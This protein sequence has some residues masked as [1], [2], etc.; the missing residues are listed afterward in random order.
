MDEDAVK[1]FSERLCGTVAVSPAAFGS[2]EPYAVCL[3]SR[4]I[5]TPGGR[6]LVLPSKALADAVAAEWRAQSERVNISAMTH[7]RLAVSALDRVAEARG[8]VIDMLLSYAGADLLCYR[9]EAPADLV[10]RQHEH[11]QP[12]LDWAAERWGAHL[13]VTGGIVPVAQPKAAIEALRAPVHALDDWQ[14][15]AL[16]VIAQACGS[17]VLALALV[18]GRIDPAET[19]A[20]SQLDETYQSERW[21]VDLEAA[22]RRQSLQQEIVEAWTFLMLARGHAIR[23]PPAPCEREPRERQ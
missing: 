6:P 14:L 7:T 1:S 2:R 15:T 5:H 4:P 17:L 19:F 23:I 10:R 20:L 9:A 18:E 21:G 12:L 11:W 16:A 13:V 8:A 22:G 3:D